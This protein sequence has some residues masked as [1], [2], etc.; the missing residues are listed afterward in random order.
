[1]T[2]RNGLFSSKLVSE[3]RPDRLADRISDCILKVFLERDPHDASPAKPWWQ[4]S[5]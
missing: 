1:M 2:I 4:I 5:A 3:G